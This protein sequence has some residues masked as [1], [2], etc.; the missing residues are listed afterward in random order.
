VTCIGFVL[1]QRSCIGCHACTVACKQEHGT[2]L[3]MFRTWVKYIEQ[4]TFPDTRRYFDTVP[5]RVRAPEQR[6]K[7]K[8]FYL[9]AQE[10]SLDPLAVA[11]ATAYLNE[12]TTEHRRRL[13]PQAATAVATVVADASRHPAPWGWRVSS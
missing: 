1:D 12:F 5:A 4:G 10:A 13:A 7:P 3:G 9:G 11:Q 6:T 8:V 2:E